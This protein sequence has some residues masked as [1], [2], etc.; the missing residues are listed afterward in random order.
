NKHIYDDKDTGLEELYS[1][2]SRFVF[3]TYVKQQR[4]LVR[5]GEYGILKCDNNIYE[6]VKI[7]DKTYKTYIVHIATPSTCTYLPILA[8]A[9]Y[10]RTGQIPQLAIQ[11]FK[12]LP[13]YHHDNLLNLI[14]NTSK[15]ILENGK[16][17]RKRGY[18]SSNRHIRGADET[19]TKK[20]KNLGTNSTAVA[21]F[22]GVKL[23][24]Y[25]S[26]NAVLQTQPYSIGQTQ[27]K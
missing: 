25:I 16:V 21:Y 23:D 15:Q 18:P 24:P 3:E 7:D 4:D 8:Y 26:Q 9:T 1:V 19:V 5:S 17:K 13:E 20:A 27:T 11:I 22:N 10:S 12:N 6:V 2:C 14:Q